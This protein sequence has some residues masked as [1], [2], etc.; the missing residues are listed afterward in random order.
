M[1]AMYARRVGRSASDEP[2]FSNFV[3]PA[4]AAARSTAA[5]I[6]PTE[7]A[8]L[9]RLNIGSADSSMIENPWPSSPSMADDDRVAAS[10]V[11]GTE[12]L[13][14]SPRPSKGAPAR[15]P[16]VS[17]G[18]SQS[19]LG[20]SAASGRLDHTYAVAWLADVTQLLRAWRRTLPP[21]IFSALDTGA[22]N[23]LREPASEKAS[24]DRWRPSAT[25]RRTFSGA[26]LSST[27]APA[28]CIVTTIAVEPHSRA[29]RSTT[30]AATRGEWPSP[31]TSRLVNRPRTPA[32]PS[33]ATASA[34]N[35]AFWST[36]DA[37][38]A[39]TSREIRS[40][41]SS[42]LASLFDIGSSRARGNRLHLSGRERPRAMCSTRHR[43]AAYSFNGRQIGNMGA[44]HLPAA[45]DCQPSRLAAT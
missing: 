34:G 1:R 6:M 29:I 12:S 16:S 32:L 8:A 18:T 33:A 40:T 39:T 9:S 7:Q 38:G 4:W 44:H 3:P 25:S 2:V 35:A 19:V 31:P 45:R 28:K 27:A 17:R 41:V 26:S 13:P 37:C 5:S 11:T 30:R 15:S 43:R 42:T 24:V 22:Q 10:A 14:R 20:A 23:M 36:G 21:S